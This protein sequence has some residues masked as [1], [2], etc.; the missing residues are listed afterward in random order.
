M[1]DEAG[2]REH[3]KI[4]FLE[5]KQT[6]IKYQGKDFIINITYIAIFVTIIEDTIIQN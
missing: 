5:W 3:E 6:E 2:L 1:W 4:W